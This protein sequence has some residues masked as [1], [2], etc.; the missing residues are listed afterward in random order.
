MEHTSE[1]CKLILY[2][3]MRAYNTSTVSSAWTVYV[4]CVVY[5]EGQ[6]TTSEQLI[7]IHMSDF[8]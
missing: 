3:F 4:L 2:W 7:I 1:L 8:S 5:S 6:Y